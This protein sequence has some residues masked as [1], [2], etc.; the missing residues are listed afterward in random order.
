[1]ICLNF[2]S[3]HVQES[4]NE[5][6]F[7]FQLLFNQYTIWEPLFWI[8]WS[9]D[10]KK[11]LEPKFFSVLGQC[12]WIIIIVSFWGGGGG[13]GVFIIKFSCWLKDYYTS[14]LFLLPHFHLSTDIT[15]SSSFISQIWLSFPPLTTCNSSM[16]IMETVKQNNK[17]YIYMLKEHLF[18]FVINKIKLKYK[19]LRDEQRDEW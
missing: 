18:R 10:S 15:V 3:V 13:R 16:K 17:T 1:M 6:R 7:S 19:W 8:R 12:P 2:L 14:I 11:S 5:P 4:S 9:K